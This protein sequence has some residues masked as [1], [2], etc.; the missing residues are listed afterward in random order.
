MF[1][2]LFGVPY[3]R[4]RKKFSKEMLEMLNLKQGQTLVDFGSGDGSILI[5]ASKKY[6]TKGIGYEHLW[7]LVQ[8]AK[9]RTMFTGTKK[10]IK[11]KNENFLKSEKLPEADAISI[12]LFPEVNV[13]LEPILRR[14]YPK[15]TRVVS[16]T[17]KFPTLNLI[18][19]K[20]AKKQTF[21]LYEI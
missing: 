10:H 1:R 6:G 19:T 14:D 12:Y 18:E 13:A 11:F 16:R 17:F 21:F 7:I 15:G 5:H 2:G 20:E 9:V 4:T 8:W 3:V